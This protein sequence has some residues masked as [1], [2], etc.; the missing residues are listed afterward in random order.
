MKQF[1]PGGKGGARLLHQRRLWRHHR[2]PQMVRSVC[3]HRPP[4]PLPLVSD[5]ATGHPSPLATA[6]ALHTRLILSPTRPSTTHRHSSLPPPSV[7]NH[8]SSPTWPS[9]THP[10]F[11]GMIIIWRNRHDHHHHHHTIPSSVSAAALHINCHC[12]HLPIKSPPEAGAAGPQP[13]CPGG[14]AEPARR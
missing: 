4:L 12:H 1:V 11:S 6:V 14:S 8:L 13:S 7:T 9:V 2:Q 5:T 10:S 3:G